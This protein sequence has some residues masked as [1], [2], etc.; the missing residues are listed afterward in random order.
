MSLI[1]RLKPFCIWHR[2]R[3]DNRFE[4]R[5]NH[6]H[7]WNRKWGL[8]N[9][10]LCSASSTCIVWGYLPL[11]YFCW[12][13]PLTE[14]KGRVKSVWDFSSVTLISAVSMTPRKSFQRFHW[15]RWNSAKKFCS[16]CPYEIFHFAIKIISAVSMTPLKPFQRCQLHHWNRFSG[17]NY[18]WNSNIIDFLGEYEAICETALG[19]ESGGIVWWKI[20]RVENLVLLS[21]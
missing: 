11:K 7:R 18:R 20:P 14:E 16:K 21:L 1:N 6:G 4:S 3:R 2:I 5:Q 10:Q 8:G 17:V 13:F 12:I 15:H 9:P 19:R